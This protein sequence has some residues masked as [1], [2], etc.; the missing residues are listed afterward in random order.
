MF[1]GSLAQMRRHFF[2]C[3]NE[4]ENITHFLFLCPNCH[5][6]FEKNWS[7]VYFI[8]SRSTPIMRNFRIRKELKIE[9]SSIKPIIGFDREE[10]N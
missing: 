6:N 5:E 1:D 7:I 10:M 8:S 2:T 9:K 3:K 4:V